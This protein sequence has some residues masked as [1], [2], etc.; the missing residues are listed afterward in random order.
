MTR[1]CKSHKSIGFQD[2][3]EAVASS[4][5]VDTYAHDTTVGADRAA[6]EV[7]VYDLEM[8]VE[9]LVEDDY[10]YSFLGGSWDRVLTCRGSQHAVVSEVNSAVPSNG[11]TLVLGWVPTLVLKVM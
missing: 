2:E 9:T 5:G 8:E 11:E 4:F 1:H 10:K 3:V 7:D 6:V